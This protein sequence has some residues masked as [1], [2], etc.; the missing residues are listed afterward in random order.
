VVVGPAFKIAIEWKP[1][2][3]RYRFNDG[4]WTDWFD[5]PGDAIN[6]F[7]FVGWGGPVYYF[8]DIKIGTDLPTSEDVYSIS[9]SRPADE[10]IVPDFKSWLL[11]FV[12][13]T[14]TSTYALFALDT[15]IYPTSTST[16]I[17]ATDRFLVQYYVPDTTSTSS[18]WIGKKVPL[19][20][21]RT[22]WADAYIHS[23]DGSIFAT[24]A[25]ISF[26]ISTSTLGVWE[27]TPVSTSTEL[28]ITCDP[29]DP[30]FQRSLCKLAVWL[31]VPSTT[32]LD[33]FATLKEEVRYKPPIGY[34][35]VAID[36]LGTLKNGTPTIEIAVLTGIMDPIKEG[37]LWLIWFVFIIWLLKRL[38]H[39]EI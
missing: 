20:S 33:R 28:V 36:V 37:L 17:W 24:S 31:F 1:E 18:I 32:I 8:D 9:I 22:Y 15:Y 2:G 39:L 26:T 14:G 16:A 25:R 6:R 21:G 35:A 5:Y 38:T 7:T 29:E 34:L 12:Y 27:E 13:Y 10:S 3:T 30:F 23:L 4:T 11:N 19:W